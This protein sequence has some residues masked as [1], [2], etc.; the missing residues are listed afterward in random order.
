MIYELRFSFEIELLAAVTGFCLAA[1]WLKQIISLLYFLAAAPVFGFRI[2]SVS[3]FGFGWSIHNDNTWHRQPFKFSPLIQSSVCVDLRKPVPEDI[4]RR[5]KLLHILRVLLLFAVSAVLI[6]LCRNSIAAVMQR[7]ET[8]LDLFLAGF[9][10]GMGV[11]SVATLVIY[12]YTFGVMMKRLAGYVNSLIKRMRAGEPVSQ[13]HL[14]PVEEL[15]YPNANQLER[16]LYYNIYLFYLLTQ[17]DIAGMR[18]P[19]QEMTA[20][21]QNREFVVQETMNYMWLIFYYSR[22]D[23]N[24]QAATI[25][26]DK[27]RH[28]LTNDPDAN[29]KRVLAYYAFGIERDNAKAQQYVNEGL[30]VVDQFSLPGEEREMERRLLLELQG[31]LDKAKQS[32]AVP[33]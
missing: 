8:L 9:S 31:F 14:R 32:S 19:I 24:Q 17:N 21:F 7:R 13:M 5:D 25:F 1:I 11:H 33:L 20:Y 2:R 4:D 26:M 12:I 15:P 30:A 16:M 18:G 29:S 28:A 27:V 6:F 3:I 10:I 22:Y 23:L